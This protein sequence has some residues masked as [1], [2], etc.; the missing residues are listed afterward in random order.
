MRGPAKAT[1]ITVSSFCQIRLHIHGL[2]MQAPVDL[3]ARRNRSFCNQGTSGRMKDYRRP[4]RTQKY[5]E[6]A[7]RYLTFVSSAVPF[8]L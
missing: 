6:E 5:R 8:R 2:Y 7:K 4:L 3:S 1:V